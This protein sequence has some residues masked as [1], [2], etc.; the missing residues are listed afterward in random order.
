MIIQAVSKQSPQELSPQIE[1][2]QYYY[3]HFSQELLLLQTKL[4]AEEQ[5]LES[6]RIQI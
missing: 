5:T 2:V 6:P 1:I 3:S 4:Y